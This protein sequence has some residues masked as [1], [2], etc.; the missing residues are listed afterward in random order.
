MAASTGVSVSGNRFHTGTSAD[1]PAEVR[2]AAEMVQERLER[3]AKG[4]GFLVLT[5]RPSQ[6]QRAIAALCNL[7]ATPVS[8][9][10]LVIG[11]LRRH[12]AAKSI[13]WDHAILRADA[14]GPGGGRWPRLLAVVRDSLAPVRAELLTGPGHVLLTY[15][16]LLA[17]YDVIGILDELRE[18]ITRQ[19][20][21][22]QTLRTLWVLVPDDDPDALPVIQG[23]AV[24][25]TTSA[26][27][28]ALPDEW[29]SNLHRTHPD[30]TQG[31]AT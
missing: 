27:H 30:R 25:V 19:S 22:G 31:S 10:A 3:H 15:P 14:E 24:P 18:R 23:K 16:G 21:L 20:E 2:A 11:A 26:E 12:A 4:G 1:A 28:L 29:L 7:G 5:V 6:Q 17:R 13:Q 9:D 8:V